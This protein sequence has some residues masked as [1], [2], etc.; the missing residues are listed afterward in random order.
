MSE[1][2]Q[3]KKGDKHVA[4]VYNIIKRFCENVEV[5]ENEGSIYDIICTL[6][7]NV[8]R[9]IQV[10]TLY[11]RKSPTI[12]YNCSLKRHGGSK[13]KRYPDGCVVVMINEDDCKFGITFAR[14][15]PQQCIT[16][17]FNEHK[18]VKSKYDYMMCTDT[19]MLTAL[20]HYAII[21]A[22]PIV[23]E[24]GC[25]EKNTLNEKES[26]KR[27]IEFC[28]THGFCAER[29]ITNG[30]CIDVYINK[31]I[32]VQ[33]KYSLRRRGNE[34][35]FHSCLHRGKVKRP[36]HEN[37]PIDYFIFEYGGC[38]GKYLSNFCII[39]K[40]IMLKMGY[41]SSSISKGHKDIC[42]QLPDC[43]RKV[44]SFTKTYW[45]KINQFNE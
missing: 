14:D 3:T 37:D 10:K 13:A 30:S 28:A 29:N 23:D 32:T 22:D 42:I 33:L 24:I 7:D 27:F 19:Q 12:L 2:A 5:T 43:S 11:K 38:D 34:T 26:I 15:L 44:D 45:N 40:H 20:L 39:P 18:K 21:I 41:L 35:S 36:Y 6:E 9:G 4:F 25:F 8:T 1:S 17:N 16:L 31:H